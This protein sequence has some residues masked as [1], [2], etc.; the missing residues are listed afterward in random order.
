MRLLILGGGTAAISAAR[1][2][3]ERGG[4]ALVAHAGLPLGGCCLHVG[5][6]PT[7]YLIR[8]AQQVRQAT[9]P[10]FPGL[11]PRGVALDTAPLLED[12]RGLISELRRR[13][14]EDTLPNHPGIRLLPGRGRLR[15]A[16]TIEVAGE[17]FSGDAVLVATGSRTDLSGLEHLP[18]DRLL[19]NENL[20]Q[21]RE[22][23]RSVV[24]LGGG[25]IA[26]ELAQLLLRL[27]TRVT[28]LQRSPRVLSAQ[29]EHIGGTL[30]LLLGAEG[31]EVHTG[32][33]LLGVEAEPGGVVARAR[34]GGRER[35][36]RAEHVLVARGRRGNTEELGLEGVGIGTDARGFVRV[37]ERLETACPGVYAAG[38]VMGG[39]MLVYTAS[40]EAERVVAR[41]YG[42]SPV[43]PPAESVPW[44]V[45]TDPQ[46]AG[47]GFSLEEAL[48]RGI[49]AEEAVLPVNRWPRF[50]T[51]REPH[52]FLRMVRDR[53]DDTL[54]G[55]RVLCA[56]AGDL[57]S[58][59]SLIRRLR[60][61]LREVAD[62]LVPYLTMGE[63]IALC[64]GRFLR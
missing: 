2:V 36:F 30:E 34:V 53:R 39:H 60:I 8:A 46:V 28:L 52:G 41:L 4:E 48:A 37:D 16:R 59:L 58:E 55:A 26:L 42:E 43:E 11:E 13:N 61:P 50:S 9:A 38:D 62:S 54:V 1:A 32:C 40:A 6:V 14:Y 7:K 33:E 12:L 56:E 22:L 57:V 18:A 15:D 17:S 3:A 47:V 5:C 25:Y 20:F 64:A 19:C 44:V 49:P 21:R 24:V 63:G 23:P 45:F 10:R 29:P 31:L 51:A 27:G 35:E